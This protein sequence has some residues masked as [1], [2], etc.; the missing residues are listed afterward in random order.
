VR[1]SRRTDDPAQS[2]TAEQVAGYLAKYATKSADDA[3]PGD[4]PHWRRIGTPSS[5]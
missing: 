1:T 5:D 2:V 4:N 3:A